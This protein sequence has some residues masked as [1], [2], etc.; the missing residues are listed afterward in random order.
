[1]AIVSVL[2]TEK[3]CLGEWYDDSITVWMHLMPLNC[4]QKMVKMVNFMFV[5]FTTITHNHQHRNFASFVLTLTFIKNSQKAFPLRFS[6]WR[7]RH[8]LCED[9]SWIPC[10]LSGLRIWPCRKLGHRSQM[11]LRS[12]DAVVLLQLQFNPWPGELPY[13]WPLKQKKSQKIN[14]HDGN[15]K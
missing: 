3:S 15:T 8:C 2:Q 11:R 12:G 7:T 1:M 4:T 13:V 5:Y 9:A 6:R 10:L 14:P